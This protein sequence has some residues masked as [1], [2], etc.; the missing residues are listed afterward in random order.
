MQVSPPDG[1]SDFEPFE[2]TLTERQGTRPTTA[3]INP[4]RLALISWEELVYRNAETEASRTNA[5][6]FA[7]HAVEPYYLFYGIMDHFKDPADSLEIHSQH[8]ETYRYVL[9]HLIDEP[10]ASLCGLLLGQGENELA[11][12]YCRLHL[13][14]DPNAVELLPYLLEVAPSRDSLAFLEGRLEDQPIR[15]LW[16]LHYVTLALKLGLRAEVEARYVSLAQASPSDGDFFYLLS[17]TRTDSE[18]AI[19]DLKTA[20]SHGSIEALFPLAR[21]HTALGEFDKALQQIDQALSAQPDN[22]DF[23][24]LQQELLLATG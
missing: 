3:V 10:P 22:E 23:M 11:E 16:H 15:F 12:A 21:R 4:D 1:K 24:A 19:A 13:Q 18:D 6:Q 17:L 5:D 2:F 7:L 9:H 8:E 14:A 20:A